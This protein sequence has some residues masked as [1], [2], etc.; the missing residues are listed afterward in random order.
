MF[1]KFIICLRLKIPTSSTTK[2]NIVKHILLHAI[3]NEKY[4]MCVCVVITSKE[5]VYKKNVT[6]YY[7]YIFLLLIGL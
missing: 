7:L 2:K 4:D 6:T 3:A 1:T 5:N